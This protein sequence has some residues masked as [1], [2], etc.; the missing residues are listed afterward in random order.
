MTNSGSERGQ[1][2]FVNTLEEVPICVIFLPQSPSPA[3]SLMNLT[4]RPEVVYH[5]FAIAVRRCLHKNIRDSSHNEDLPMGTVP[6]PSEL[7]ETLLLP[8][9]A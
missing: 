1:G 7:R 9:G 2:I 5:C 4:V 3:F 6:L 8:H